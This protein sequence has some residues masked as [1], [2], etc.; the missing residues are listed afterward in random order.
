M[1]KNV[2]YWRIA[3]NRVNPKVLFLEGT[4]MIG[5]QWTSIRADYNKGIN[6]TE[7]GKKYGVKGKYTIITDM[8]TDTMIDW[9]TNDF[10]YFRGYL[11]EILYIT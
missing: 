3:I 11:D 8:S 9:H 10:R 6:L 7:L 5:D 4:R 1:D 2:V